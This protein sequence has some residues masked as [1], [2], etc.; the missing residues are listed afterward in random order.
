MGEKENWTD[1]AAETNMEIVLVDH[2]L[3]GGLCGFA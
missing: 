1:E 2:S 3:S